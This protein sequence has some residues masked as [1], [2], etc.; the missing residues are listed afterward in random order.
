MGEEEEEQLDTGQA[1]S[2]AAVRLAEDEAQAAE[3]AQ[4]AMAAVVVGQAEG[5]AVRQGAPSLDAGA[6]EAASV[7]QG[8]G[9]RR[10]GLPAR[11]L[12]TRQGNTFT[13]CS[14]QEYQDQLNKL[15]LM[16]LPELAKMG[17]QYVE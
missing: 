8:K 9:F 17:A 16:Q 14:C 4:V 5:T 6:A 7:D 10:R 15:L 3:R 12:V 2:E 13:V 11:I 1:K